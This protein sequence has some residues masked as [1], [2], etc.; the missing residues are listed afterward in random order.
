MSPYDTL[1]ASAAAWAY[2]AGDAVRCRL[3]LSSGTA[4]DERWVDWMSAQLCGF[5][6]LGGQVTAPD[7]EEELTDATALPDERRRDAADRVCFFFSAPHVILAGQRLVPG[8]DLAFDLVC[9]ALPA[10]L[11]PTHSG[12]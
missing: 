8:E 11:P 6:R 4:T 12:V 2:E 10:G 5:F 1:H 3:T 7:A 9:G